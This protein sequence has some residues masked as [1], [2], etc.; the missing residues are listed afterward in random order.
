MTNISTKKRVGTAT[1]ISDGRHIVGYLGEGC[2][3][4]F[5]E[6]FSITFNVSCGSDND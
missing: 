3:F 5:Q 4:F 6:D 1:E 2:A